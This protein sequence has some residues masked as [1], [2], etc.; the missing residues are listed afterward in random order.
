[1]GID[2]ASDPACELLAARMW[3]EL[4]LAF[5]TLW[6]A[7]DAP[8]SGDADVAHTRAG[9][10]AFEAFFWRY[11]RQIFGFLWRMTMDEQSAYDLAQEAFLR[12]WQHFSEISAF[13]DPAPWLFRVASNLALTHLRRRAARPVTTLSEDEFGASDPGR[14]VVERDAVRRALLRLTP[15]QRAALVL[16]EVYGLACDEVGQALGLSRD[17]VKMALFRARENFRAAYQREDAR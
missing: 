16:H 6:R 14:R 3:R 4:R 2:W 7:G 9:E 10:N 12:A 5:A 17:A 15:N 13:R 8:G 11:E 1:M